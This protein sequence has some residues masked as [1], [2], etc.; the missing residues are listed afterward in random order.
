[1]TSTQ[2]PIR[3]SFCAISSSLCSVALL[4]V[5][6]A[7]STGS[8]AAQGLSAPVRP[9]LIRMSF[10]RVT[11]TSGANFR[12]MAQRGSRPP[13]TPSSPCAA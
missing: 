5:T 10:T 11:A 12:A 13:T 3:M 2:S 9:T 1:M 7:I 4:T 8:S 6:P